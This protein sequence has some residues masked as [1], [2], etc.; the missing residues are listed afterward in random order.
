MPGN[1]KGIVIAL[2]L[3][4]ILTS[5]FAPIIHGGNNQKEDIFAPSAQRE[6]KRLSS[7]EEIEVIIQ[8][9]DE[10][11]DKDIILLRALDLKVL[12]TYHVIPAVYVKGKVG[13]I[14]TLSGY[15]RVKRIDLNSNVEINMELSLSVINTTRAWN[16][17]INGSCSYQSF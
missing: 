1:I 2:F 12:Y 7:S 3:L 6:V 13:S 15:T 17:E 8:F 4:S 10:V 9:Q 14:K 5:T 11:E 16:R